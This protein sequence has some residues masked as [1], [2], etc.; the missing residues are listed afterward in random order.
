MNRF[1]TK[2]LRCKAIENM[3]KT[4]K[5]KRADIARK[6]GVSRA[7]IGRDIDDLSLLLNIKEND[8]LELYIQ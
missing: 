4:K 7:T 5:M 1:E 3:L 6:L 8:K 2:Y